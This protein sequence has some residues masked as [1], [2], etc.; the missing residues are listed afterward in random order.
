MNDFDKKP[1]ILA[2]LDAVESFWE[3]DESER[4][5]YVVAYADREVIFFDI[6]YEFPSNLFIYQ[7][8]VDGKV[9]YGYM[10]VYFNKVTEAISNDPNI[11]NL[12]RARITEDDGSYLIDDNLVRIDEYY[13]GFMIYDDDLLIV[14]WTDRP[15]EK[16]TVI[17]D[18]DFDSFLVPVKSNEE[19]NAEGKPLYGYMTLRNA[20]SDKKASEKDYVI[21]PLFESAGLFYEG[22]AAVEVYDKWG[23]I[24]EAGRIIIEPEYEKARNFYQDCAQVY[25]ANYHKP[26]EVLKQGYTDENDL[27]RWGM[28]NRMGNSVTSFI[29]KSMT[30]FYNDLSYA[31]VAVPSYYESSFYQILR[32]DGLSAFS[33]RLIFSKDWMFFAQEPRP[34]SEGLM[35]IA[36]N[37]W[38]F[39]NENGEKAF[40]NEFEKAKGFSDGMAAVQFE[41]KI[42]WGYIDMTGNLVLPD[43]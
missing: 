31:V 29:Y 7:T 42:R 41:S 4:F 10:D 34:F 39:I 11:F 20:I 22:L 32:P 15:V 26:F 17:T 5:S 21:P 33:P 27:G 23:Y 14:D 28:I 40:E 12:G 37:Y 1:E 13:P 3:N 9:K 8:E 6:D 18:V 19:T 38:V 24:D 2:E 35:P 16:P 25:D 30:P 36:Y 43:I